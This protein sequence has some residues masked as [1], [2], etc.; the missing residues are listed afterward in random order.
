MER[1]V[2]MKE[3]PTFSPW[4]EVEARTVEQAD[5]EGNYIGQD[6]KCIACGE[7]ITRFGLS[8]LEQERRWH[9]PTC[10]WGLK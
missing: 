2:K 9:R 8:T 3:L 6:W 4:V 1:K 5:G 10:P 7:G